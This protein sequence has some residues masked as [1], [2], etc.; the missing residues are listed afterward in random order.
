VTLQSGD[1]ATFTAAVSVAAAAPQGSLVNT[2]TVA[3][4]GVVVDPDTSN[5][6]ATDTDGI[7]GPLPAMNVL[8]TFNRANANTLGGNW[9]QVTLFGQAA[10]RTNNNQASASV[11]GWAMWNGAGTP[12]G[13]RQGA[14]FKFAI[15]PVTSSMVPNSLILKASG[16]TANTPANYIQVGYSGGTVEVATT[17]GG[18]STTRASFTATFAS[19]DTL[20][21]VAL[22]TGTVNVYKTSGTTTTVV[23]S[24]TIPGAGFWTG[25]GRIGLL[26]PS[27]ARVDDFKGQTLP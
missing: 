22:E 15:T 4:S 27:S 9:S 24:V 23:G 8:D 10:I 25:T 19:G 16:G 13:A 5:N 20:S 17:T 2:A 14:A 18:S 6:S 26:L 11:L 21:A 12:F 3:T 1:S 7:V